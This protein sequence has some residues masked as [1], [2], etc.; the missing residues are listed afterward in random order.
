MYNNQDESIKV[1]KVIVFWHTHIDDDTYIDSIIKKIHK[2]VRDYKNIS[3]EREWCID[4]IDNEVIHSRELSEQIYDGYL[5]NNKPL[6]TFSAI[7]K[8]VQWK[9][10]NSRE[11]C[12]AEFKEYIDELE[13]FRNNKFDNSED[14]EDDFL[15][16]DEDNTQK[17]VYYEGDKL[18]YNGLFQFIPCINKEYL[19]NI[20]I[21]CKMNE[22]M[23]N[24]TNGFISGIKERYD[25]LSKL[26]NN[27]IIGLNDI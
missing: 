10:D 8:L 21:K 25:K 11:K 24:I 18:T 4:V 7:N 15:E 19:S 17:Q 20:K 12:F 22:L 2:F 13:E 1:A 6:V 14:L 26:S 9:D 16:D 23:K 5:D 27:N 3:E